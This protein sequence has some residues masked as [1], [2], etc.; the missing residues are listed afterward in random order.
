MKNSTKALT[1]VAAIGLLVVMFGLT[2]VTNVAPVSAATVTVAEDTTE[3]ASATG[4]DISWVKPDS[5]A[6][7]FIKDAALETTKSG[8]AAF[9]GTISSYTYFDV[10]NSKAGTSS[11][12]ATTTNVTV[13]ITASDYASTTPSSTPW[14]S[15][16]TVT[17]G[18]ATQNL[19]S[20]SLTAGTFTLITASSATTTAAFS[21]HIQDTWSGTSSTA[22]RAKVTSTS[23]PA[24]EYVTI[25]EVVSVTDTTAAP[26]SQVFHGSIA[27]SSDAAKQGA[28][29][30]GVW[31]QDGDT[32][33][34]TYLKS[35]GTTIDTDAVT[36]DGV[37]PTVTA[38]SPADATI[39][40]VVNPTITFDVTD[41]GAGISA[42]SV[43]TDV[44]ISFLPVAATNA[45]T[46]VLS[47]LPAFQA[48][49]DGF[50]VIYAT[51]TSWLTTYAAAGL[52]NNTAFQWQIEA[53]DVAGNKRTVTGSSLDLTI[54]TTKPL[55]T[56]ASTGTAWDTTKTTPVE[57]TGVN[58][59]VKVTFSE[60]LDASSVSASDFTVADVAPSAA[61]VG[62]T[63]G[64]KG[65]VYLTV[66]AQ[67]PDA[68]PAVKVVSTVSDKAGNNLDTTAT[69]ATQTST[70]GLKPSFTTTI[71]QAL[72]VKD[73]QVKVTIAPD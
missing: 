59:A 52:A 71:S 48:I 56:G 3:W 38:I 73:D 12:T 7:F 6:N 8:T 44:T 4:Q 66:A 58:T 53:T 42:T 16:P 40:N 57:K 31:V 70:D 2:A 9:G 51:G 62:T 5:T 61:V 67:A 20:F 64:N 68:K 23:D 11:G 43:A 26:K 17:V 41:A 37:K 29:N 21:Y 28:N 13:T 72:G 65:N 24:G 22:R 19:T 15:E 14:V 39:T 45:T 25:S 10:A 69:A 27:L 55:A 46:S 1:I 50:R 32:L 54:D 36:V 33:T 34:V 18:T 35:D 60:D 63:A 30:D 47:T 49:T